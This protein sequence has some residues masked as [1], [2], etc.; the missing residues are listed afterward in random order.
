MSL[1]YKIE[2]LEHAANLEQAGE[3]Q[4]LLNFSEDWVMNEPKNFLAW[5]SMGDA[6][7]KLGKPAEAIEKFFKGLEF[8]PAE[9][10]QLMGKK[11]SASSFWY[12]I[13]HAQNELGDRE[14]AIE[15]FLKATKFDSHADIWNDLGVM[16]LNTH[17][18]DIKAAFESFQKAV[19]LD[20]RSPALKNM[21]IVYAMCDDRDGIGY[22]YNEMS[23]FN[24]DDAILFLRQAKAI[25]VGKDK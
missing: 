15:S 12:R 18:K 9:P 22:V 2:T 6:L 13:G 17:P 14:N 11:I 24:K 16:Y 20:R 21:G 10:A 1:D 25:I 8:I 7:R 23:K 5:Q 3:W 19:A 4:E